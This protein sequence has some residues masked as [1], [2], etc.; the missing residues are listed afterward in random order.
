[1]A[2][3]KTTVARSKKNAPR[4]LEIA[5]RGIYTG[6]DFAGFMSAMM[7]DI[8]QSRIEPGMA[9]AACNAGGK[10]L[11]IVEM[12]YRYGEKQAGSSRRTLNLAPIAA[13]AESVQ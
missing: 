10:L 12:Q 3:R 13:E 1:M 5:E 8:I 6:A 2:N 4:C 7:S 11:K 9:N